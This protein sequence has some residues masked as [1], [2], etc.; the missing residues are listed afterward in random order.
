MR[1]GWWH[2]RDVAEF[3]ELDQAAVDRW[4]DFWNGL[5]LEQRRSVVADMMNLFVHPHKPGMLPEERV[6]VRWRA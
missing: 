4:P 2:R 5:P 6:E 3:T 1:A